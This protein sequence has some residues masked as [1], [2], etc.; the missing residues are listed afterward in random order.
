MME[1]TRAK[2]K[3]ETIRIL[4]DIIKSKAVYVLSFIVPLIIMLAIYIMRDIFPSGD[5]YYLRSDMYHQY[6][7]FF[8][9]L[10]EKIRTGE[11]LAYSWDIGMGTNFLALFGYYLSSPV[12]WFVALFPQKWIVEVMDM[13]IVL[14]IALASFT[15][16]YYL[17]K[18]NNKRHLSAAIFG[19]FYALS[20]FV[21]AYS[22]N[23]MWLDSV[24]LF[25]LIILGIEKLVN[26]GK[27]LLYS[28][29]LGMA[30]LSNYYIA[31]MICIS[32]VIYFVITMVVEVCLKM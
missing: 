15:F 8:S 31:I 17:C 5:N 10:W 28:I 13:I 18:H 25:P 21:T 32:S 19:M 4:N 23:L 24:L 16:T 30:I 11:S 7:P 9:Q 29:S 3:G 6:A 27:G 22:W 20:G 2:K 26:E 14:K 12:N 1:E